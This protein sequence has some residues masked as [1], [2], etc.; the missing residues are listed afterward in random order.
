MITA[1]RNSHV[2]IG[3]FN[4]LAGRSALPPQTL[5]PHDS[6]TIKAWHPLW[7]EQT[8]IAS[9]LL[10]LHSPQALSL[11]VLSSNGAGHHWIDFRFPLAGESLFSKRILRDAPSRS[12]YCPS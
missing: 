4:G 9:S 5:S 7:A 2:G 12:S 10:A 8:P 11:L 6:H 3:Y 1:A